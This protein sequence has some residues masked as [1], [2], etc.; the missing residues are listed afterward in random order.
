MIF[1]KYFFISVLTIRKIR[2]II[3]LQV[4]KT[5]IKNLENKILQESEVHHES[6]NK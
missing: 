6:Q 4:R 3:N 2:S 5:R 1:G